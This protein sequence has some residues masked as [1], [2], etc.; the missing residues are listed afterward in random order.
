MLKNIK[1]TYPDAEQLILNAS[2]KGS[3]NDAGLSKGGEA[4]F[5]LKSK[6]LMQQRLKITQILL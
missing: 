5:E 4:P 2:Y 6:Y 1:I 3:G